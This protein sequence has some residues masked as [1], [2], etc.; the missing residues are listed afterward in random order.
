MINKK[1]FFIVLFFSFA[2]LLISFGL[3]PGG[4]LKSKASLMSAA[5]ESAENSN[6]SNVSNLENN[7]EQE[8]ASQDAK[9]AVSG[10]SA[11]L[12]SEAPADSIGNTGISVDINSSGA[13]EMEETQEAEKAQMEAEGQIAK[14]KETKEEKKEDHETDDKI[15]NGGNEE[16]AKIEMFE[17]IISGSSEKKEK[18]V[19]VSSIKII[20]I[21]ERKKEVKNNNIESKVFSEKGTIFDANKVI[22]KDEAGEKEIPKLISAEPKAVIPKSIDEKEIIKWI[23]PVAGEDKNA[24]DNKQ[25]FPQNISPPG[26]ESGSNIQIQNNQQ[27]ENKINAKKISILEK[28]IV[29]EL[30]AVAPVVE[31]SG[32]EAAAAKDSD[33]DGLDDVFE[34][35]IGSDPKKADSDGDKFLDGVE[36][37]LG[38]N[39]TGKGALS[40]GDLAIANTPKLENKKGE[41][42]MA[43]SDGDGISD[44][45]EIVLGTN[46]FSA[47]SDNDGFSD[48]EEMANGFNPLKSA[49]KLDDK[50]SL[51]DPRDSSAPIT[52]VLS[53][54][55]VARTIQR[56][57]K[58]EIASEKLTLEGEGEPDSFIALYIFSDPAAAIVKTDSA[59][60]WAYVLDKALDYGEH[61]I[62]AAVV[63]AGGS[64]I[65]KSNPVKFLLEEIQIPAASLPSPIEAI[66]TEAGLTS[67]LKDAKMIAFISFGALFLLLIAGFAVKEIQS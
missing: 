33:G 9:R 62:Y 53:I 43:D 49:A 63:D 5:E 29:S 60:K 14:E 37:S 52:A 46:P 67:W 12:E 50:I 18:T 20:G 48:S 34:E 61:T 21:Q 39:P 36:F 24:A 17:K 55:N 3:G 13:D 1:D 26:A 38:Y 32:G 40:K 66:K 42:V 59:G 65:A 41:L 35:S 28:N 25:E 7:L 27:E 58:R 56:N 57:E 23:K 31:T 8:A 2:A 10:E 64:I 51:E 16:S 6:I 44:R 19:A 22:E 4:I 11:D 54:V 45:E 30:K 15:E 47:D